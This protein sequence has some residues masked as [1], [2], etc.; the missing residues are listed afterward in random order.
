[1]INA[2]FSKKEIIALT[3]YFCVLLVLRSA[4][5]L[6]RKIQGNESGKPAT[7]GDI[8]A[9]QAGRAGVQPVC[10]QE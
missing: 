8:R 3:V 6:R 10:L 7:A 2:G 9:N 5:G 1:M 4:Y